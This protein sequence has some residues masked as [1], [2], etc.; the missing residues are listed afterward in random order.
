[1]LFRSLTNGGFETFTP[2]SGP[3]YGI[4][5]TRLGSWSFGG[6]GGYP[7]VIN[8]TIANQSSS[9][10]LNGTSV[11]LANPSTV[12]GTVAITASPNAGNF[13]AFENSSNSCACYIYTTVT[14]L[15]SGQSYNVSFYQAG[16]V[17]SG[18]ATAATS[19]QWKVGWGTTVPEPL[20]G[21]L[22]VSGVVGLIALRRRR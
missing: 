19:D 2:G 1:M 15:T 4:Q 13:V 9:W 16:A 18:G 17:Y 12:S 10:L 7:A 20:S 14:G 8:S 21:A 3:D 6:S 11:T 5:G 22:L